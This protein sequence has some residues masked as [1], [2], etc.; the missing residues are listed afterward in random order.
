MSMSL[1]ILIAGGGPVGAIAAL[2]LAR[3]GVPVQVFEAEDRVNDAPRAATTHA[4]TLE[5]LD[6]LELV[7]EV[8]RCGLIAPKFSIWD[9]TSGEVIAT[10]D[11]GRLKEDTCYP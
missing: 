8:I 7:D 1:P 2:S 10:F 6:D 5:M 11:F 4:A 9:R 3:H